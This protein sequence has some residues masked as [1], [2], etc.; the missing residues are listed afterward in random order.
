MSEWGEWSECDS[1]CGAGSQSRT[2]HVIRKAHHGGKTCPPTLQQRGCQGNSGCLDK[3]TRASNK[4]A[5]KGSFLQLLLWWKR[6]A[7]RSLHWTSRSD[8]AQYRAKRTKYLPQWPIDRWIL[9]RKKCKNLF[10]L[11]S[12]SFYWD[13]RSRWLDLRKIKRNKIEE[14]DC[15]QW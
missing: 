4:A 8:H 9:V 14:M 2:R 12:K 11:I 5:L 10:H 3:A 13:F 6:V 7:N 15:S 1:T